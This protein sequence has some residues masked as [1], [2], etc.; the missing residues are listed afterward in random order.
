MGARRFS[1]QEEKA[2]VLRYHAGET[3]ALIGL[4]LGVRQSTIAKI[5]ARK[6]VQARNKSE[7]KIK[8][9]P[10]KQEKICDQYLAGENTVQLSSA[11]GVSCNTINR[12]LR[13]NGV[14][15]RKRGGEPQKKSAAW[16]NKK[17]ICHRYVQGESSD[18]LAASYRTSGETILRILREAGV[19]T[20]VQGGYGDGV[21]QA[22]DGTGHYAGLRECTFY[23][24]SLARFKDTHCKPGISFDVEDRIR[25]SKGEYGEEFLR[26]EL[27]TRQEAFFLEQAV[28]H[29]TRN[30][31]QC[32][33]VLRDWAGSHE[34]RSLP[35]M[36]ALLITECLL[37]EMEELGVWDFAALRVPMTAAQRIACQQRAQAGAGVSAG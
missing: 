35:P 29:A 16:S 28:L 20:R 32:P 11:Y 8:L 33:E 25:T 2:I 31:A 36:E 14:T 30:A 10:E 13:R 22:L 19:E 26:K 7:V 9:T 5:L 12:A 4:S 18:G 24:F 17:E 1:D 3:Q 21:Q 6:G 23:L 34:V 15:I 37:N 27:A